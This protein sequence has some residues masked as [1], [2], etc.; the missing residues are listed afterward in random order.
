MGV[1]WRAWKRFPVKGRLRLMPRGL[2]ATYAGYVDLGTG[3]RDRG[4][5]YP[6]AGLEG[7]IDVRVPGNVTI[8]GV[9]G[10][11][12]DGGR[13]AINGTVIDRDGQTAMQLPHRKHPQS[14]YEWTSY[15]S[16]T[17]LIIR[18]PQTRAQRPQSVQVS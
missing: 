3:L 14:S 4:F 2:T 15:L 12:M 10:A 9:T 7:L 8:D 6:V 5:D 17:S 13:C 16:P 18:A 1:S 11:M